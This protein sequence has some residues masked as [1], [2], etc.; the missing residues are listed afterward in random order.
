[1]DF[2][3]IRNYDLLF[4]KII[5]GRPLRPYLLN[6]LALQAKMAH[7]QD[8]TRPRAGKPQILAIFVFYSPQIFCGDQ[9]F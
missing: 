9:L 6:Q 4:G 3:V 1:M 5:L 7:F 2:L 8:Q